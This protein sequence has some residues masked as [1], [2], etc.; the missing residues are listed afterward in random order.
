MEQMDLVHRP[1]FQN[2]VIL[3]NSEYR[4]MDKVQNTSN[5]EKN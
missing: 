5:S 3:I 1:V 2:P 4:T